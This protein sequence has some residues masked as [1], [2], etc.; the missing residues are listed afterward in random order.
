[1]QFCV[2]MRD[3]RQLQPSTIRS[4]MTS[5]RHFVESTARGVALRT[6]MKRLRA[7][8][9]ERF[10][11]SYGAE[12]GRSGQKAIRSA[13]R[14]FLRFCADRAWVSAAVRDSVPSLREYRLSTVPRGLDDREIRRALD[15][16]D[17]GAV[18]GARDRAVLLLLSTYGVRRGQVLALR[19]A[20]VDWDERRIHF[21]AHKGGVTVQGE[22]AVT[23][24]N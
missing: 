12:H 3:E 20:D 13:L 6:A 10:F 19:V 7:L 1:M 16:V 5:T 4:L 23:A 24:S 8:D 9:V 22:P 14:M 17:D 15:L 21:R 18:A 2:W 11:V